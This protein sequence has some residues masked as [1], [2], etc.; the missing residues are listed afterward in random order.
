MRQDISTPWL[1]IYWWDWNM[2]PCF[3]TRTTQ[4]S[5]EMLKETET[6]EHP[7]HTVV[8]WCTKQPSGTHLIAGMHKFSKD[9]A[10]PQSSR[11]Q[12]DDMNVVPED[13]QKEHAIV[14]NLVTTAT[15][16]WG[17]CTPALESCN[18]SIMIC[19]TQPPG[20]LRSDALCCKVSL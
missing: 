17:L 13:P 8:C 5:Y 3:I 15:W 6:G 12:K 4:C 9:L 20:K 2:G 19:S 1:I 18:T 16:Y 14:Q 7:C 11:H 10:V